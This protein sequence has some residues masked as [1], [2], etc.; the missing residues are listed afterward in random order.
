MGEK[1]IAVVAPVP[2]SVTFV[3]FEAVAPPPPPPPHNGD[4]S[5]PGNPCGGL[6][7]GVLPATTGVEFGLFP[8]PVPPAVP[9]TPP[10][11]PGCPLPFPPPA[12]HIV[13]KVDTDPTVL[14]PPPGA[15][16]PPGPPAPPPPT[17]IE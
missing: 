4:A 8:P 15:S 7:G 3:P 1:L 12:E 9:P 10:L 6:T 13:E 2:P 5:P 14:T 16:G 17:T 11:F